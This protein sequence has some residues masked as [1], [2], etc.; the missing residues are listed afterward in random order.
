MTAW[1][2]A[3]YFSPSFAYCGGTMLSPLTDL[4]LQVANSVDVY[5]M[6]CVS[7][8][9]RHMVRSVVR[10]GSSQVK[11]VDHTLRNDC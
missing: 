6:L 8:S 7:S 9:F 2:V 3:N 5:F 4:L 11:K 1:D 10:R